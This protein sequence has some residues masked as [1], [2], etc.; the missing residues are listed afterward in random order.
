M[1]RNKP[2]QIANQTNTDN[3]Q[4]H[5][6][7]VEHQQDKQSARRFTAR[8]GVTPG[9]AARLLFIL[10]LLC[11]L[12]LSASW[13]QNANS[14]GFQQQGPPNRLRSH[15]DA[16]N[17]KPHHPRSSRYPPLHRNSTGDRCCCSGCGWVCGYSVCYCCG[18]AGCLVA[19]TRV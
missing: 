1:T 4:L 9:A 10:L 5:S 16:G 14:R 12:L 7:S 2:R 13:L 15:T 19:P 11:L 6:I 18:A 8:P 17:K 3:K